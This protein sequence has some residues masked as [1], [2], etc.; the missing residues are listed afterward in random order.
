MFEP[1]SIVT[2][3]GDHGTTS[4][5]YNRRVP[6]SHPRIEACGAVDELNA[7][8]GVARA[9]SEHDFVRSCLCSVQK[10]LV[11][12]MGEIATAMD[13][14][15]RYTKDGYSLVSAEMT[16]RLQGTVDEIEAQHLSFKGWAFPGENLHSAALDFA[17]A[18][19]RRAERSVCGCR[20]TCRG[21]EGR[22]RW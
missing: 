16:A 7:V 3:T 9:T 20:R 6:K 22:C 19:C 15:P 5:M 4:L 12:L 10:D 11:S 2:R 17:R 13:D 18:V 14:L 21:E 1:M 8:L